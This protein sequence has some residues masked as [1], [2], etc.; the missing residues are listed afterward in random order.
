MDKFNTMQCSKNELEQEK[1]KNIPHASIVKI[2]MY[3][4][5]CTRINISFTV[6]KLGKHQSNP[7]L[8]HWSIK[9]VS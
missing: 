6:R 4:Q 5:T 1:M 7:S 2:F 9:K 8:D 3:V